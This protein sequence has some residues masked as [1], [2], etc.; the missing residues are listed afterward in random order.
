MKVSPAFSKAAGVWGRRPQGLSANPKALQLR[1]E[2]QAALTKKPPGQTIRRRAQ[3]RQ[4][5]RVREANSCKRRQRS[6]AVDS[7]K[8]GN[9]T[10][11]GLAE[12]A[13]CTIGRRALSVPGRCCL[14]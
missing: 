12:R 14:L 8:L 7:A 9:G 3:V 1:T 6:R 4:W 11:P 2:V 13:D 10:F 5:H